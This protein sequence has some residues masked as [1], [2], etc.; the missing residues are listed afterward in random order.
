MLPLTRSL[1]AVLCAGL[2]LPAL[3]DEPDAL[4]ITVGAL[5]RKVPDGVTTRLQT[6][7]EAHHDTAYGRA[8]IDN[9]ELGWALPAPGGFAAVGVANERLWGYGGP[10]SSNVALLRYG[11]DL[12][13]DGTLSVGLADRIGSHTPGKLAVFGI[14]QPVTTWRNTEWGFS[15]WG[16][17]A[18]R[19]RRQSLG[20]ASYGGDYRLEQGNWMITATYPSKARWQLVAGAGTRWEARPDDGYQSGWQTLLG[21]RWNASFHNGGN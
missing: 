15:Y 1:L 21:L 13:Q 8:Y 14:D 4:A 9:G 3:A 16:T 18:D 7:V 17:A 19:T 6:M 11:I 20:N 12:P 2:C 10:S 5:S